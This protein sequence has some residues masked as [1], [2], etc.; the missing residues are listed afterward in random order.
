MVG[1]CLSSFLVS[2]LLEGELEIEISFQDFM[3]VFL[4]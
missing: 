4:I 1:E 2:L 3:L